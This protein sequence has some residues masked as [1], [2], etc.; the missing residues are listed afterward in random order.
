M[1][2]CQR[3]SASCGACCGLYNRRDPGRAAVRAE[4]ARRTGRLRELPRTPEAF[5][6]AAAALLADG[7]PPLFPSV[8]VCPLL[9]F[10]DDAGTRVGC[11]AHPAATGGPDLRDC[12][13]YDAR[14]CDTFFCP[15]FSW[16]TEEEAALAEAAVA[17][18][19]LYGLVVTDVPFLRAS[20]AGVAALVGARVE[21]RHVAGAPFRAA[22]RRLLA[23]KEELAPGS[24]GIFGAF[25]ARRG[26][27]PAADRDEVVPRR[28]DY[29]ALERAPSPYDEILTCAGA[30]PRSGN[31]LDRLESEVRR[32]LDAC[33]ASFPVAP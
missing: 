23:L 16:L 3:G 26:D 19:H 7:P 27:G 8:R 14:I 11:L 1:N 32:R 13:A 29:P 5:G 4:L 28:L 24:D 10:L 15:S 31:D 30:D 25:A 9:G 33:A 21:L 22:L 20:L 17:D 2:L 6:A 18:F 12:G